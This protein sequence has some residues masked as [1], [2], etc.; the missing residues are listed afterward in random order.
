VDP[1]ATHTLILRHWLRD[2]TN[3]YPFLPNYNLQKLKVVLEKNPFHPF[4]VVQAG[5]PK[6]GKSHITTK[7]RRKNQLM[8]STL[9]TC[10]HYN[11][12][13]S[14][15]V[16]IYKERD[17]LLN[18]YIAMTLFLLLVVISV[19]AAGSATK[20]GLL[21][22]L[23]LGAAIMTGISAWSRREIYEY[24]INELSRTYSFRVGTELVIESEMSNV[25]VRLRK[26]N[27]KYGLQPSFVYVYRSLYDI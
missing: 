4:T 1:L 22:I 18:V 3:Y 19:L 27:G 12:P 14:L 26:R 17:K 21:F 16:F 2:E 13:P 25:Y 7:Q 6:R 15:A 11:S 10:V 23:T 20:S 24:T 5:S 8:K 9:S